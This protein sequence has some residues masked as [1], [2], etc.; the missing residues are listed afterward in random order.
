[1]A[2]ADEVEESRAEGRGGQTLERRENTDMVL[3][4]DEFIA[5]RLGEDLL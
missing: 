5:I 1:M 2:Q 3:S 4:D